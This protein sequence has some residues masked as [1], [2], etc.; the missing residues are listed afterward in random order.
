MPVNST[1]SKNG[2]Q[3]YQEAYRAWSDFYRQMSVEGMEM[4]QR[5]VE[6]AQRMSPLGSDNPFFRFWFNTQQDFMNRFSHGGWA[7]AA[8]P[9][10]YQKAYDSWMDTLGQNLETYMGTEEF[11]SQSGKGLEML[12][13]MKK[14]T[15]ELMESYWHA[16][17]L[18][19]AHDMRELY[20]KLYVIERK[21]DEMDRR[22][23]DLQSAGRETMARPRTTEQ[24]SAAPATEVPRAA[25]VK[26]APKKPETKKSASVK[27]KPSK[28]KSTS[29]KAPK[30]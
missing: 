14:K 23:R 20:H 11:A 12:S 19:S 13:D 22:L 29:K 17:H 27:A 21:L 25:A 5:G 26:T 16:L 30:K 3:D 9:E 7:E 28:S 18:P 24:R 2:G 10:A 4:F 8:D 1:E 15:G 6:N